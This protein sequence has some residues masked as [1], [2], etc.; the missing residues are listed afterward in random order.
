LSQLPRALV[1][2]VSIRPFKVKEE[3]IGMS[4]LHEVVPIGEVFDLIEF[5][6]D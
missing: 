4:F 5:S 2:F 3:L 6:L 1:F